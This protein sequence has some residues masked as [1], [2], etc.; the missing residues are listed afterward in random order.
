MIVARKESAGRK[1]RKARK[2]RASSRALRLPARPMVGSSA[3]HTMDLVAMGI[4][5]WCT[6]AW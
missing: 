6:A 1:E 4:V 3:L 2:E 5:G